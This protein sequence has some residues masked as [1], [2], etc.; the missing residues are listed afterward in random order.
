MDNKDF[1][2]KL[3]IDPIQNLTQNKQNQNFKPKEKVSTSGTDNYFYSLPK[4][5]YGKRNNAKLGNKK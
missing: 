1:I 2:N 4:Q 3:Y 5:S